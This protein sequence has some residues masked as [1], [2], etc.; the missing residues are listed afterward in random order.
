[1]VF[2]NLLNKIKGL[3]DPEKLKSIGFLRNI[4]KEIKEMGLKKFWQTNNKVFKYGAI[5]LALLII[6]GE[7]RNSEFYKNI[8]HS[9]NWSYGYF[10]ATFL[11]FVITI[12]VGVSWY[13]S[14]GF[15]DKYTPNEMDRSK[16]KYKGID[17]HKF[18]DQ[19]KKPG[20]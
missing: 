16:M 13:F 8:T 4:Y 6:Y 19:I 2:N 12:G 10:F 20:E 3:N 9:L 15:R 5:L 18:E 11:A 7:F 1:M 17:W 14:T